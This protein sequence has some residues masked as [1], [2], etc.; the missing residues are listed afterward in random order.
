MSST[1]T[2]FFLWASPMGCNGGCNGMYDAC[3]AFVGRVELECNGWVLIP[4]TRLMEERVGPICFYLAV[5]DTLVEC[6]TLEMP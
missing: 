5:N 6:H 4:I 2:L 1:V 3:H